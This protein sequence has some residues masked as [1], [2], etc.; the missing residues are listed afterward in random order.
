VILRE[1]IDQPTHARLIVLGD[2]VV[3]S[4]EYVAQGDDFRTNAGDTPSVRPKKFSPEMEAIA[5]QAVTVLGLEFGGVDM[6]T[7]EAGNDVVLET[8]FP[9]YFVRAQEATGTDVAGKMV[10]YLMAKSKSLQG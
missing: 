1:F 10:E 7:D 4:I 2:Q 6:M 5:V 8:N 9:C 3:D